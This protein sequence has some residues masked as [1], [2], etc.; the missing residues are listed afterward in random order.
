MAELVLLTTR[1]V[2]EKLRTTPNAVKLIL[3]K[4]LIKG[5]FKMGNE[6]R[7]PETG[8][9]EYIKNLQSETEKELSAEE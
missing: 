6:W 5:A 9:A 2:A 3:R 1:E 7:I 8:L 4:K